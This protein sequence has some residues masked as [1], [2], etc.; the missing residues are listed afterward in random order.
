MWIGKFD[1]LIVVVML[2]VWIFFNVFV[3][4]LWIKFVKYS[5]IYFKWCIVKN[6]MKL[7]WCKNVNNF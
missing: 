3:K 1:K 5:L 4:I 6:Y 2:F 7:K